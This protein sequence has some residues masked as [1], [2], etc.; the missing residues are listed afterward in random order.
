MTST[1]PLSLMNFDSLT[2]EFPVLLLGI[3]KGGLV[4]FL[5]I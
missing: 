2:A 3:L 4:L 1:D 5:I